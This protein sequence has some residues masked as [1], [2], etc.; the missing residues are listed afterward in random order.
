VWLSA[1]LMVPAALL[2]IFLSRKLFRR[3][4]RDVLLRLVAVL[5]LASG[6]SLLV[7]ALG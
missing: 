7:R 1:L 4:S 6:G 5:L 2:A 3:I